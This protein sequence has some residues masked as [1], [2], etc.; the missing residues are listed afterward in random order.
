M[1]TGNIEP[2]GA[3]AVLVRAFTGLT[4]QTT[5]LTLDGEMPVDQLTPGDRVITR[6][7]GM[8]I[9]K[10]LRRTVADVAPVSIKAGSLGHTRPGSDMLVGPDT[11]ILIRDWRAHALF[12]VPVAL[13]PAHRLTD[14][15]FVTD[16]PKRRVALFEL[17]FDRQHI[18]YADGIELA[19]AEV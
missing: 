19:S 10:E 12:G 9:L 1:H 11:R 17:V 5:V 2:T 3:T 16:L 15:E 18:V 6:D 14:G 13:V 4:G 7:S 8:A